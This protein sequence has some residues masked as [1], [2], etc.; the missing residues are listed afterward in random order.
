[1]FRFNCYLIAIFALFF[2]ANTLGQISYQTRYDTVASGATFILTQTIDASISNDPPK[3]MGEKIPDIQLFDDLDFNYENRDAFGTYY[4]EKSEEFENNN[5][6][7]ENALLLNKYILSH[8]N[9]VIPPDPTIAVGPNHVMVLTNFSSGIFIYDKQGNLL[10]NVNSNQFWQG[11][12][13]RQDG[14]PQIIFDHFAGRWV[15]VFM[16]I[17]D[18]AQMAGDLLAY[19]DDDDPFG[20]WYTYRLPSTLWGDFPQIG[21]DH[22]GIYIAT[23]VFSFAGFGQ[24]PQ[25]KII[26]KA[27]LYSSNGGP[28]S[29]TTFYNIT[30]PGYPS[31]RAFNIRP[32]FQY[33]VANDHYLL[34][35]YR[36]S[37][38]FAS[39]GF[40]KLSN[41][42]TNP[43]LT[44]VNIPTTTYYPTPLALQPGS[45]T[46][47][48]DSIESGG[49]P[50]RNA[51]IY[52]DG[53]LYA[54]HSVG[55]SSQTAA[56]IRYFKLD[57]GTN[58]I[59][60]S[61]EYGTPGMYHIYPAISVDK[62][63][64]ILINCSRSSLNDYI[65]AYYVGRRASDPP[66]L[67]S[68]YELQKGLGKYVITFGGTRNR[69]G[70]Y[71]GMF[72]D[73]STELNFWMVTEFA[74][75]TNQYAM[76]IGEVRLEP[77][78]GAFVFTPEIDL[79][80]GDVEIQTNGDTLEVV[81]ANYGE[82]QLNITAMPEFVGEFYRTSVHNFPVTLETYDSLYVKFVFSPTSFGEKNEFFPVANNST[83]FTGFNLKG[84]G[85]IINPVV[86]QQLYAVSGS[87]NNGQLLYVDKS[88][89]AGTNIGPTGF[90]ELVNM[91]VDPSSEQLYGVIYTTLS[92]QIFRINAESGDAYLL[93]NFDLPELFSIAFDTSGQLYGTTIPGELY[94]IDLSNQ[95]L[96]LVNTLPL[97]RV[98]IAFN[99]LNNQLWG[100]V[101]TPVGIRDR[102]AKFDLLTGDTLFVGRTGFNAN[103]N[104]I[105]FDQN[106]I[107]YGIKGAATV[108]S[109]L[110]SIDQVTGLGTII[111]TTGIKNLTALAYSITEP[112]SVPDDGLVVPAEFALSQNYPNPFN[113][114]TT[115][116]FSLPVASSVRLT[117]YNLLGE[118][119]NVLLDKEF[120]SG[121]YNIV[122]NADDRFGK[123]V[124]SGVYFYELRASA[125]NG[126]EFNQF[127][128]MILL[129]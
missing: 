99:P 124:S 88:T 20:T 54:V 110:I 3:I 100:S 42:V 105:A 38:A 115:I 32:S 78:E 116:N 127:R 16:Q 114:Y 87:Q 4:H 98:A 56:N 22:Q 126:S 91:T 117:I 41:P 107:L 23:N 89:G 108:E 50:I 111:G 34:W 76:A 13:P 36:G 94:S 92:S 59:V 128:K 25:L 33:T 120:Q 2:V 101:K 93:A 5:A 44:A 17:D 84:F 82:D 64:N 129:K 24:Y 83:N 6:I 67:S 49:S 27:E 95:T 103:T 47:P 30:V 112:T 18:G 96:Q 123:K 37:V 57:V 62:N 31:L 52:R 10:S 26:S 109:D 119:V 55:N 118:V 66:G 35:A 71:M 79:D 29:F 73:P 106:G 104:D 102:I 60:E 51:P 125:D 39:Y 28:L 12:W 11:I 40:Y 72:L 77:F 74:S 70:D 81:I 15:I 113:P 85:Y 43:V 61:V 8:S 1:M 58:T 75:G 65:G 14:D 9:N 69:W 68:A 48:A 86:G 45:G 63:R 53:Y 121:N 90:N 21:F 19:S 97:A 80:F 46:Q 122:W 7:G